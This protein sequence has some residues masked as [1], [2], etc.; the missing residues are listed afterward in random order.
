M[1]LYDALDFNLTE[2]MVSMEK[3]NHP[4]HY[5]GADDPY[6]VIKVM[7]AWLTFEEFVGACKFNA[8]KYFARAKKKDDEDENYAKGTWYANYLTDYI[9]RNRGQQSKL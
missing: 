2:G 8:F 1:V 9:K 7:E 5:G 6:E 4:Q 3:V